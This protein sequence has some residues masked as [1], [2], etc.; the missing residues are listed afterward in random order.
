MQSK[1]SSKNNSFHDDEVIRL[2]KL[3]GIVD[4]P[5]GYITTS[6][7]INKED[8]KKVV[9]YYGNIVSTPLQLTE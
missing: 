4:P 6:K 5:K 2:K 1:E 9:R 8:L 3:Y 7:P